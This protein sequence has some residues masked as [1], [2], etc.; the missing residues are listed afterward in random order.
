ME[1]PTILFI[2]E[3]QEVGT[4]DRIPAVMRILKRR[5]AL[6]GLPARWGGIIYN[7]ER[8][9]AP[10]YL[11]YAIERTLT[12][13]RGLRIARKEK[14]Q[15]VFCETPHHALVGLWIARVLGL[16]CIWDSHGNALLFAESMGRSR[17]YTILSSGVD[18]FL[19]RQVD[20]LITVSQ[21]DAEAYVR[22]GVP[23]SRIHVIPTSADLDRVDRTAPSTPSPAREEE[24]VKGPSSLLFF[25]SF[26]YAPNL[27]AL[28][29]INERLAPYLE[30]EGI[31]CE[32]RVAGRDV[33]TGALHP[34]VRP[35]GFVE[36]IHEWIRRS[37]M[38]VVPVWKGVGILTKV[39]DIMATGTPAVLSGFV[40]HGIPEIQD[41]V[42]AL[43][44]SRED[45]FPERVAFALRHPD[46]MREMARN[47]RRL[48]E[49]RYDWKVY[50]PVLETLMASLTRA[51]GSA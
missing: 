22:M 17:F 51:R 34:S 25:G 44:V 5:H 42:H 9:K 38:C 12:A 45:E 47:A 46:R 18:R 21:R 37:D 13:L 49:E 40:V 33:P 29:F 8:A 3:E 43:V 11:L 26:K 36:D 14:V 7:T 30:K 16:P 50:E 35:L 23:S 28:R 4:S 24:R 6:V 39:V 1:P 19:G 20:A 41:G 10:R 27:D 31:P 2:P 15:L 32:I 48:V